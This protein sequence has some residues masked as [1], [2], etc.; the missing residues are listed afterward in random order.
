M[1]APDAVAGRMRAMLSGL[2]PGKRRRATMVLQVFVDDSG[3]GARPV[4]VLAGWLADSLVWEQFSA[5]WGAALAEHPPIAYFKM[6]EAWSGLKGEFKGWSAGERRKKTAQLARII[7][8]H[9]RLGVHLVIPYDQYR[10]LI[11]TNYGRRWK[12]PY[13]IGSY[14]F[15][16]AALR[17]FARNQIQEPIDFIFDERNHESDKF[18]SFYS[19]FLVGVPDEYRGMIGARPRHE[20]DKCFVPLQGADMLAWHIRRGRAETGQIKTPA[21]EIFDVEQIQLEADV[22][23]VAGIMN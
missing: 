17:F 12:D 6:E 4:F 2:P 22:A 8:S 20:D 11:S 14:L 9:A 23:A 21:I 15:I 7:K 5:Q 16:I 1:I 3:T 13:V 18:Q 19:E 10:N